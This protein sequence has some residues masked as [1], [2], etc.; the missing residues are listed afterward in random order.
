MPDFQRKLNN[1]LLSTLVAPGAARDDQCKQDRRRSPMDLSPEIQREMLRQM[2]TI[3]RFEERASVEYDEGRIFGGLH[4]YNGEEAV[5]VGVCSALT[6]RIRSSRPIAVTVIASR[7]ARTSRG[8]LPSSTA[9]RPAIAK[10]RAARCILPIS[11]SAC[12]AQTASWPAAS[13]SSQA[14]DW[15]RSLTAR[16]RSRFRSSVTAP[17][18][19][20]LS[21]SVSISRRCGS[22]R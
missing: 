14:P 16:A 10:A 13:R 11:T 18:M 8:C 6:V 7:K 22:C 17:R 2:V 12:W 19:P 9:A 4:C 5:A 21:M 20:A 3:R 1:L 15:P